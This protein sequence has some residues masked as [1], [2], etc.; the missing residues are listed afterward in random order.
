MLPGALVIFLL[1]TVNSQSAVNCTGY[2]PQQNFTM[3]DNEIWRW[4]KFSNEI[5]N[6]NS[7]LTQTQVNAML[8]AFIPTMDC[9]S[10]LELERVKNIRYNLSPA[11]QTVYLEKIKPIKDNGSLTFAQ[12]RDQINTIIHDITDSTVRDALLAKENAGYGLLD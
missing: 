1:H 2:T 4:V 7:T 6:P 5:E 12:A 10:Q 3:S 9:Q 8:D 11:A